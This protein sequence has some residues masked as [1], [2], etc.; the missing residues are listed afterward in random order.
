MIKV[1]EWQPGLCSAVIL[2]SWWS[3]S[4]SIYYVT[5][6]SCLLSYCVCARARKGLPAKWIIVASNSCQLCICETNIRHSEM[7]GVVVCP[8]FRNAE[9]FRYACNEP[10]C[11]MRTSTW[12]GTAQ[13]VARRPWVLTRELRTA[14]GWTVS[15]L[16]SRC[17]E[18]GIWNTVHPLGY[19]GSDIHGHDSVWI[20][21]SSE[22]LPPSSIELSRS[23]ASL[24]TAAP[25]HQALRWREAW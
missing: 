18:D 19:V 3:S 14:S 6:C 2:F 22:A 25:L 4:L 23:P 11:C 9:T 17:R 12:V 21:A 16:P 20:A 5:T 10:R 1:G 8:K 24:D 15:C 13:E 7:V